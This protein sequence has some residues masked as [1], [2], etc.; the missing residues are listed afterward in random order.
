MQNNYYIFNYNESKKDEKVNEE[1]NEEIIMDKF[2]KKDNKY[3]SFNVN[4][5]PVPKKTY[6]YIKDKMNKN[7]YNYLKLNLF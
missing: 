5:E 2:M 7:L 4:Y 3:S 1:N 6:K